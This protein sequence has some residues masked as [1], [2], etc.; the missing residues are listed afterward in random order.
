MRSACAIFSSEACPAVPYFPR[1]VI[2]GTIVKK[3]KE[4]EIERE[5]DRE[6]EKKLSNTKYVFWFFSTTLV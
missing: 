4:R 6:R 2:N 3:K 5:R 1:Y